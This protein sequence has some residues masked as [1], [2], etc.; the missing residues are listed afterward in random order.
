MSIFVIAEEI[1][2]ML[3]TGRLPARIDAFQG[4]EQLVLHTTRHVI[5]LYPTKRQDAFRIGSI[6]PANLR[7]ESRVATAGC[8]LSMPGC[9]LF[10]DVLSI[11]QNFSPE[12]QR[13]FTTWPQLKQTLQTTDLPGDE[14]AERHQA[15]LA[16][17][18]SIIKVEEELDRQA[19]QQAGVLTYTAVSSAQ[20]QRY[21]ERDVY[22][23]AVLERPAFGPGDQV[24]IDGDAPLRAGVVRVTQRSITLR[25][26]RTDVS[27]IPA[28][29]TIRLAPKSSVFRAQNQAVRTL[30]E[31]RSLNP[32]LLHHL[33]DG[34]HRPYTPGWATPLTPLDA[35]QN[36]VFRRALGIKDQLLVLGPP[37]TGKTRVLTAIAA[38]AV[39]RGQRILLASQTNQAVD[40]VLERLPDGLLA[41]RTGNEDSIVEGLRRYLPREHASQLRRSIQARTHDASQVY[42]FFREDGESTS[43][44]SEIQDA[45]SGSVQA[46]K[47]L[48]LAQKAY[49]DRAEEIRRAN[50]VPRS[51]WLRRVLLW[52]SKEAALARVRSVELTQSALIDVDPLAQ[53]ARSECRAQQSARE[54]ALERC[55][56]AAQVLDRELALALP[57]QHRPADR[58]VSDGDKYVHD[59]RKLVEMARRR[60]QLLQDWAGQLDSSDEVL[61]REILRYAGVVATTCTGAARAEL[62]ELEFDLA[63]IDEAGQISTPNLLIPLVLARRH[64]LVGDDRQLPP[65]VSEG[66]SEALTERGRDDLVNVLH[67]STFEDL[68]RRGA[69]EAAHKTMLSVQRRMPDVLARFISQQFYDGKLQ[70]RSTSSSTDPSFTSPIAFIDTSDQPEKTRWEQRVGGSGSDRQRSCRNNF[71]AQIIVRLMA[72]RQ[73]LSQD[74]AVIVPYRAQQLRITELLSRDLGPGHAVEVGTVDRFQGGER[75]LIVFGFTRSNKN[76]TI[77]FLK[78]LRRLNVA[79]TRARSQLILVGDARC[80]SGAADSDFRA[81]M[82]ELLAYIATHGDRRMSANVFPPEKG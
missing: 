78:E 14:R 17:T 18:A 25:M 51:S 66:V 15:Y 39:R 10:D 62:Q 16:D 48:R 68:Y 1:T 64:V 77:G 19:T 41:V 54:D 40:N 26:P 29:G 73:G 60:S 13:R 53:R 4:D 75:D 65:V 7:T 31:G 35:S 57:D 59:A 32:E 28:S 49:D 38:E 70:S 12:Q 27:A 5:T 42:R 79:M 72:E 22:R 20:E 30:R 45:W 58:D 76:G 67:R 9:H 74:A 2:A 43:W 55:R 69:P 81:F 24:T 23:F 34:E 44:L 71:E 47:C 3:S 56:R 33:V 63:L 50:P 52:E 6:R 61:E 82:R 21:S 80:L 37:G 8:L 46:E 36:D 11:G